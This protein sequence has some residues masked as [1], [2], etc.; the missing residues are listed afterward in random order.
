MK[1]HKALM[2]ALVVG[3]PTARTNSK[4]GGLGSVGNLWGKPR[5]VRKV[6][7]TRQHT[8]TRGQT[9]LSSLEKLGLELLG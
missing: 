4:V 3:A 2:G 7:G 5:Q 6:K 9:T 1:D 8:G